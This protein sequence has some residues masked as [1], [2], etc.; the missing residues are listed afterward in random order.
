MA[1]LEKQLKRL[2]EMVSK[3]RE[4]K[5]DIVADRLVSLEKEAKGLG[6]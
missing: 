4:A 3:R 1:E 5:A 2:K 6:W